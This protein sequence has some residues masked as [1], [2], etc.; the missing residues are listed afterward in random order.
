M[1]KLLCSFIILLSAYSFAFAQSKSFGPGK[2]NLG[3][4]GTEV[5]GTYNDAYTSGLGFSLKYEVPVNKNLYG[6]ISTGYE[7]IFAKSDSVNAGGYKSSYGFS[8]NKVGLKYCYMGHYFVEA[9]AGIILPLEQSSSNS[10]AHET[11]TE[12]TFAYSFGIGYTMPKGIEVGL[13]FESWDEGAAF[14]Q[15]ALRV[16]YRF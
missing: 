13:R 14:N 2:L 15:A 9:Q 3:I 11:L 10:G 6:T 4:D 7:S 16:A 5:I 8:A 12:T 1:K